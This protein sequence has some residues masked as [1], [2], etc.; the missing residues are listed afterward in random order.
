MLT[1]VRH[2]K[3]ALP[4]RSTSLF[5]SLSVIA[6]FACVEGPRTTFPERSS[7]SRLVPHSSDIT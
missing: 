2:F 1:L 5:L 3:A 4:D 7:R 6:Q